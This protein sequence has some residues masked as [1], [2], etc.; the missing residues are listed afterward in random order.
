[1][2][3][4]PDAASAKPAPFLAPEVPDW[5]ARLANLAWLVRQ[6]AGAHPKSARLWF[7][8]SLLGGQIVPLHLWIGK[9]TADNL[10]DRL[11]GGE[12]NT[13][14]WFAS[15]WVVVICVNL[16]AEQAETIFATTA[17]ERGG[18]AI[19]AATLDKATRIDLASFE[20]QGFYDR[21]AVVLNDAEAKANDA[22]KQVVLF[23]WSVPRMISWLAV[24]I[25]FDWRLALLASV[26]LL[27]AIWAWM[28][29]G[30]IYWNVFRE[31]TRD[32]RLATYYASL[33][34]DR[35]AA[36]EIR[37]FGL[38]DTLLERWEQSYWA[39]ARDLRNRGLRIGIR[40]RG[41]SMLS[42]A[43]IMLGLVW[44]ISIAPETISAGTAVVVTSSYIWLSGSILNFAQPLQELGKM[45][46]FATDLRGFL[47]LPEESTAQPVPPCDHPVTGE[48]RIENLTFTYPGGTRPVI[49][50]LSLTIDPG[51]T[52]ALVG[53]N[54]AGKTT[55]V[56]LLLG[57]Y[58]PDCGRVLLDGQNLSELDSGEIRQR[59]SGVFQ[60]F[61]HYPFT[62]QENVTLVDPAMSPG[63]PIALN[64]VGLDDLA[65]QLPNALKTVLS[66]DLGEVDL[67]GGQ[68]QRIAIAR[69]GIR[70]ASVLALD[71][72]TASLDP[73]AEVAIFQRFAELARQRTTILVSH[74]LG[75]ARLA[76]RILVLEHG[77][78]IEQG[79]HDELVDRKG[80]DYAAMWHAQSRWYQ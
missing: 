53:E 73:L 9:G 28:S 40:Q 31:Q 1:M 64:L 65:G 45:S 58:R 72:P 42:S 47:D 12:G 37:L 27:P 44:Y 52:I 67:S 23:G 76:D 74:R 38:T 16:V 15:L 59:L 48:L 32:R 24:L 33:L 57:L 70:D 78:I 79:T 63:L 75:M 56:K 39:T 68:W 43:A 66:P 69:A 7:F 34:T 54:G 80:S 49:R 6:V 2:I 25:V 21:I 8:M 22:L 17:R 46:G 36:K 26:P 60:Q 3:G 51:E 20:H 5:R 71:E 11:E 62:A 4:S 77:D 55:L 50:N 18:S 35:Q 41:T 13:L 14:W 30:A 29:S 61:I 10:Q 19:A